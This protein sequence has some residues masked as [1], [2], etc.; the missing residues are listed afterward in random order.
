MEKRE[1]SGVA[2]KKKKGANEP[3]ADDHD[4]VKRRREKTELVSKDSKFISEN[5]LHFGKT[6]GQDRPPMKGRGK[7]QRIVI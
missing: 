6:H 2:R 4:R 7:G 5:L 3:D 1:E